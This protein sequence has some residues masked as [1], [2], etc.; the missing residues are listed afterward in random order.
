MSMKTQMYLIRR[1][2]KARP[3]CGGC[4]RAGDE[5]SVIPK[6]EV[7]VCRRCRE[8]CE[9]NRKRFELI[10]KRDELRAKRAM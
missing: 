4:E 5:G 6:G 9:A 8:Q 3:I 7:H 10:L 1:G 2:E